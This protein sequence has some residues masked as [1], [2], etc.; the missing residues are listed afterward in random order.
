MKIEIC[1]K[2]RKLAKKYKEQEFGQI[3]QDLQGLVL[4]E[5]GC[6]PE[7]FELYNVEGIDIVIDDESFGK[8]AIEVKTTSGTSINVGKKDYDGL[9]K[10]SNNGYFSILAVLKY[11]KDSNL[12]GEWILYN[13]KN[14]SG[15]KSNL[16]VN[17]LFTHDKLKDFAN[18]INE[19]FEELVE[20]WY[21]EIAKDGV[22]WLREK[23]KKEGVKYSGK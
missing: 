12:C 5:L 7:K 13:F 18:K 14:L 21:Q 4:V 23:L 15:P 17:S 19:K 22:S 11:S 20:K 8:Y 2:I 16:S 9:R 6:N 10:F 1:N 3:L